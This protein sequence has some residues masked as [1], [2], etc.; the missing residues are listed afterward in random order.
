VRIVVTRPKT[1]AA[2]LTSRLRELGAKVR[3]APAIRIVDPHS[4][5]GLD[6]ALKRLDRYDA[7]IFTSANAVDRFFRRARHVLKTRLRPPRRLFAIGPA[8]AR[9]LR[10][11]GWRGVGIPDRYE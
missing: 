3:A 8:T 4:W 6:A 5:S 2:P 9:A 10:T 1:Q 11:C 7:V